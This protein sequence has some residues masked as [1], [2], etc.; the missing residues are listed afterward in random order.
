MVEGLILVDLFVAT[1]AILQPE[2]KYFPTGLIVVV[3]ILPFLYALSASVY[4]ISKYFW[5]VYCVCV[6]VYV[7]VCV[8]VCVCTCVCVCVCVCM[9]AC[10]YV[11]VCVCVCVCVHVCGVCVYVHVLP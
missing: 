8:C 11:C 10:V 1:V 4:L 5:L 3:I 6:C 7:C 9:C 2:D